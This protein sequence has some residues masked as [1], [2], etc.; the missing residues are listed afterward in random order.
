M[1]RLLTAL[2]VVVLLTGCAGIPADDTP[3]AT[4]TV[5]ESTTEP[6]TESVTS[7]PT[8]TPTETPTETR[9]EA[10][11]HDPPPDNP[12]E[13][14]PITVAI[15]RDDAADR[16]F[17]PL[18]REALD[19]WENESQNGQV[20]Y[21]LNFTIVNDSAEADIIVG[22]V[23]EI[24]RC[25]DTD[26]RIAGCADAIGFG[27]D[28]PTPTT[29]QTA[30]GYNDSATVT[31]LKHEFGHTLGYTHSESDI[32]DF[33]IESQLYGELDQP[34][35]DERD[36][37][38]EADTIYVY[39]NYSEDSNRY[40]EG[41]YDRDIERVVETYNDYHN[42]PEGV[43][44]KVTE[45][46]SKADITIHFRDSLENNDKYAGYYTY[47]DLDYDGVPNY[48]TAYDIYIGDL[49]RDHVE[50]IVGYYVGY[51]VYANETEQ[52]PREYR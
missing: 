17:E 20:G 7:T 1:N 12:W 37:H 39:A 24:P 6:S 33:M 44:L 42:M 30:I 29:V 14:D 8:T 23:A 52:L 5:E 34:D 4:P 21:E 10:E 38:W 15:Y 2:A 19:F 13:A 41:A 48:F 25:G 51:S 50:E 22:F 35:I 32:Y 46:Q 47:V 28:A 43:Q 11:L 49:D 40:P 31:V 26:E 36:S 45:N 16:D 27:A 9:T 18:L 3:V